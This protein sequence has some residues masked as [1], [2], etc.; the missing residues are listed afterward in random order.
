MRCP[1]FLMMRYPSSAPKIQIDWPLPHSSSLH[2]TP[3]PHSSSLLLT[4][5]PHSSAPPPPQKSG[6]P[7]PSAAPKSRP[8]SAIPPPK[9]PALLRPPPPQKAGPPPPFLHPKIRVER[10]LYYYL[11]SYGTSNSKAGGVEFTPK[12]DK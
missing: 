4:P 12:M 11:C 10:P 3:P 1:E 5:P 8:S 2:H 7:P 9:N 6:P